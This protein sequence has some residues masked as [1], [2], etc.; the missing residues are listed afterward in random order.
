VLIVT[1][2][3][4]VRD[5]QICLLARAPEHLPSGLHILADLYPID[6]SS[7]P[8]DKVSAKLFMN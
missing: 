3:P 7:A 4:V 2:F 5:L 1:C 8:F 6:V